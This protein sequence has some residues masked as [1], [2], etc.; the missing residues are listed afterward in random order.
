MPDSFEEHR[1][2]GLFSGGYL[3]GITGVFTSRHDPTGATALLGMSY[4]IP[5]YRRRGLSVLFYEI[6]LAWIESRP[7]FAR[8]TV[9]HRLSNEASRRANQRFGF[10]LTS[11][12]PNVW[13]DGTNEEEVCYELMHNGSDGSFMRTAAL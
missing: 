8:V 9:S 3:I 12:T 2:F 6:R 4:I 10:H 11:R 13:P 5:G 7:Q 1:V